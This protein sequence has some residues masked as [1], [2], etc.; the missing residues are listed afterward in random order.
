M[1]IAWLHQ[2]AFVL[3]PILAII[4]IPILVVLDGFLTLMADPDKAD[5][6]NGALVIDSWP[7]SPRGDIRNMEFM[8]EWKELSFALSKSGGRKSATKPQTTPKTQLGQTQA[9]E[10][11]KGVVPLDRVMD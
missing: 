5:K 10:Y 9:C 4:P 7:L 8:D 6:Y 3:R 2:K 11:Q 1:S